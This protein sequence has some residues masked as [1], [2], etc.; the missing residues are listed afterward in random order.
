MNPYDLRGPEF[1]ALYGL[2]LTLAFVLALALRSWL[3][4]PGGQA[5]GAALSLESR[6]RCVA[7]RRSRPR[8]RGGGVPAGGAGAH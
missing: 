2:L 1:L 8:L 3:R 6:A 4:I 5:Q 7:G